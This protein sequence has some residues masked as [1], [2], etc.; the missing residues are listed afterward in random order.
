MFECR[1]VDTKP[2]FSY[3][4]WRFRFLWRRIEPRDDDLLDGGYS[5][6]LLNHSGF[7]NENVEGSN[8]QLVVGASEL[9]GRNA[10]LI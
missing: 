5:K 2:H 7:W 9:Q 6:V 1:I 3:N 4:K 10:G 8:R